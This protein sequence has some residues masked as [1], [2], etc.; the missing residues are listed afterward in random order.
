MVLGFDGLK[1]KLLPTWHQIR[2]SLTNYSDFSL[3]TKIFPML[4][5]S[6]MQ[7][8]LIVKVSSISLIL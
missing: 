7:G 3:T 2:Q 1:E 6:L 5:L 4:K 8:S